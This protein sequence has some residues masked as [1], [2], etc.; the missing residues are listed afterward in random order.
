VLRDTG[1]ART[2][3]ETAAAP[4]KARTCLIRMIAPIHYSI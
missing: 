1:A 4:R 2:T 3:D